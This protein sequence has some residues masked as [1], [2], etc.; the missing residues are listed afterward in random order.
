M[1][2]YDGYKPGDIIEL[3]NGRQYEIQSIGGVPEVKDGMLSEY[4]FL[5][6][7][8]DDQYELPQKARYWDVKRLVTRVKEI[9][10]ITCENCKEKMMVPTTYQMNY[11]NRTVCISCFQKLEDKD[12]NETFTPEG[13]DRRIRLEQIT[14]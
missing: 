7:S 3:F 4:Y 12:F 14:K 5:L 6:L 8:K 10:E 2:G 9:K 1:R 13:H 11:K